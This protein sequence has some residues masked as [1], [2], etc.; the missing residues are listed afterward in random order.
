MR[1]SKPFGKRR[2]SSKEELDKVIKE[3]AERN[4][5]NKFDDIFGLTRNS[6]TMS[7]FFADRQDLDEYIENTK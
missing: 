5:K 6:E 7:A 1:E 3:H 4:S 2:T